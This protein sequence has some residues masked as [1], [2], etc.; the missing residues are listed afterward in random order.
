MFNFKSSKILE[1]KHFV[2]EWYYTSNDSTIIINVRGKLS[3]SIVF[4][5]KLYLKGYYLY[6]CLNGMKN[7]ANVKFIKRMKFYIYCMLFFFVRGDYV[8][9]GKLFWVEVHNVVF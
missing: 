7:L 5:G 4:P 3:Y 9:V 6:V 2:D 8:T 1:Y